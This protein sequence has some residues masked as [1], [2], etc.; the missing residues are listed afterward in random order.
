VAAFAHLTLDLMAL[1]APPDLVAAAQ[2]D[3]LD[4]VRHTE[5]CFSL[6]RAL[7]GREQSPAP[8]PAARRGQRLSRQRT[9]ALAELA[10]HSLIDGALHEGV[11]AA[12]LGK[13]ARSCEVPQIAGI[14]QQIAADEGRH[15]AHGWDVLAWCLEAGGAPVASALRGALR[16]LPRELR[17][18][19][20]EA[21]ARGE[22]QRFG[23]HGHALE[24]AEYRR[25]SD[26]LRR[27]VLALSGSV[28]VRP[29]A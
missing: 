10:V 20:P 28:A 26:N 19:M 27:R 15:A 4:E 22:W 21:A 1:G 13:L 6:A 9:L 25:V 5:L 14:L 11:S 8:F 23:I 12:V 18:A 2:R 29:A 7:D 16:V 17:S 3:A 24:L